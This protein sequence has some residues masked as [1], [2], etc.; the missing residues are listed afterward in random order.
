M[1][2][3]RF[4]AFAVSLVAIVGVVAPSQ[5]G[6]VTPA[7]KQSIL[8]QEL[9]SASFFNTMYANRGVSP[10]NSFSW[11]TDLCS[12]SPDK[13]LGVDFTTPCRRHDFN[14]RN[15]KANSLWNA[16]AKAQI[17]TA[18]YDDMKAVCAKASWYKKPTCYATADTYYQT[19][20][21]LGT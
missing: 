3:A 1:V 12:W 2:R 13:P 4:A 14:Y 21:K 6:A 8:K 16:T 10:Y 17:D 20:R 18:F 15:F 5:A 9:A 7:Q 11:S 19:V